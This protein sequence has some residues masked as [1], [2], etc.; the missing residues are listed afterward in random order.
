MEY[1]AE[2]Q[3]QIQCCADKIEIEFVKVCMG[4]F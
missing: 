3:L 4:E 1:I 2:D